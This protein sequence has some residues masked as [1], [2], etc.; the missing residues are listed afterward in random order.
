MLGAT[1]VFATNKSSTMASTSTPTTIRPSAGVRRA[2]ERYGWCRGA[3]GRASPSS[4]SRSN[5]RRAAAFSSSVPSASKRS[6]MAVRARMKYSSRKAWPPQPSDLAPIVQRRLS[7]SSDI[8][9]VAWG[10]FGFMLVRAGLAPRNAYASSTW[11]LDWYLDWRRGAF[12][13]VL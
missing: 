3:C 2:A 11:Y 6:S 12:S 7:T 1:N 13:Y 10:W 9:F 4:S 5:L 8:F